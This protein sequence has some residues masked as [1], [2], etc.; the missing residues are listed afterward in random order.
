MATYDNI[1]WGTVS[2]SVYDILDLLTNQ[3][4][5]TCVMTGAEAADWLDKNTDDIQERLVEVGWEVIENLLRRDGI[6]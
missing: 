5:D 4:D 3:D 6:L 1:R 2:W